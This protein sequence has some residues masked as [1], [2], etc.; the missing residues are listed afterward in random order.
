MESI[1]SSVRPA[2]IRLSGMLTEIL[3]KVARQNRNE[4]K[5]F[6]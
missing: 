3:Q 4:Q 2:Y 6:N 1:T 5:I